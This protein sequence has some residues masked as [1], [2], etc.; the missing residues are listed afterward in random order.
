MSG[1]TLSVSNYLCVVLWRVY[2]VKYF[3][4]RKRPTLRSA[5]VNAISWGASQLV[6]G[7]EVMKIK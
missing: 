6:M 4:E 5:G 2:K 7:W 1:L 3:F